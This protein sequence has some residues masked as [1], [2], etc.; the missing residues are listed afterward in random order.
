[1]AGERLEADSRLAWLPFQLVLR[2]GGARHAGGDRRHRRARPGTPL[3]RAA[4]RAHY[5]AGQQFQV[6]LRRTIRD[7]RGLPRPLAAR[8]RRRRRGGRPRRRRLLHQRRGLPRRRSRGAS[9]SS[10][11]PGRLPVYMILVDLNYWEAN[12]GRL[13]TDLLEDPL[14][15]ARALP[16]QETRRTASCRSAIERPSRSCGTR[17]PARRG[18][19]GGGPARAGLAAEV[20]LGPPQRDEPR[21]LLLPHEPARSATFR[22]R[23][24]T[25]SATTGRSPS[26]T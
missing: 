14:G 24:T 18:S 10:T 19:G 23:P 8:L 5:W 4:T 9:A 26:A 2:P 20:R 25:W 17:W 11:A 1:M 13:Y 7:G 3:H 22:S 6:E 15:R 21:G 12:R 16:R